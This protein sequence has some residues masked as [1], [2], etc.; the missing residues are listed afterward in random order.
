MVFSL[1]FTLTLMVVFLLGTK[2]LHEILSDRESISNAMQVRMNIVA[3][4]VVARTIQFAFLIK[5]DS[6]ELCPK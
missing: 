6:G 1:A 2:S 3:A 5:W 4:R